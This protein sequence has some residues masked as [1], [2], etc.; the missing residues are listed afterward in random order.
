MILVGIHS[1]E[2]FSTVDMGL[3]TGPLQEGEFPSAC[4]LSPKAHCIFSALDFIFFVPPSQVW[5]ATG[6]W[7]SIFVQIRSMLL[8]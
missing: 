1:T 6:F 2:P 4:T 3:L 5:N 7:I 8:K